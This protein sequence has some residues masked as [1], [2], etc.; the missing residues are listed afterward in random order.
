MEKVPKNPDQESRIPT[1]SLSL[2]VLTLAIV[3]FLLIGATLTYFTLQ[4][5]VGIV[6]PTPPPTVTL[7]ATASLTPT[8]LTPTATNTAPPSPTPLT[9]VVQSGDI[10]AVIASIFDVSVGAIVQEN[11]L[12]QNCT[13]F[14]NQ[15]LR[16]PQ[17]THTATPLATDT[18]NAE[19]LTLTACPSEIHTVIEGE[20]L[21]LIATV[22]QVPEEAIMRWNKMTSNIVFAGQKLLIPY[23]ERIFVGGATVTPSPA[24]PYPKPEQL[25]PANGT[26]F[27]DPDEQI[28][29]Q[30]SSIGELRPNEAYL[31]TIID[32]TEGQKRTFTNAV[33]Q[34]QFTVPVSLRP[35]G[36]EVHIFQWSVMP[37]AQINVDDQ[38]NPVWSPGGP[39]STLWYFTWAGLEEE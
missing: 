13:L 33:T 7:T 14:V 27:T 31:V 39:E 18:P 24:P 20:T 2:P 9:Y 21:S 30:W 29:L 28:T 38:G 11:N 17:P 8:P 12:D 22:K 16:I 6:D 1:I 5:T 19:Q 26:A 37:V 36:N 35:E 10:C 23:C 25:L 32:V 4:Q 34:T 3:F 15:E